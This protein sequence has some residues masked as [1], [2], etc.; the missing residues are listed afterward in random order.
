MSPAS[1]AKRLE[2]AGI[3]AEVLPPAGASLARLLETPE[4]ATL[5]GWSLGAR[6]LLDALAAGRIPAGRR[7]ILV[8][9]FLAFPAEAGQGGRVSA[10]QVKFL[11][12]WLSKDPAAALA[13]FRRRAGI[14]ENDAESPPYSMEELED[15]LRVLETPVAVPPPALTGDKTLFAGADDPL[16]DSG[17]LASL[18]PGLRVVA[19]TGHDLS[20]FV[21][22]IRAGG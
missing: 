13:D 14:R 5:G 17:K 22:S 1:V 10:T 11:R 20:D 9:P 3:R 2:A 8:C 12:R 6:L 4:G 18:L 19:G 7:L 21:K 16:L 15:G